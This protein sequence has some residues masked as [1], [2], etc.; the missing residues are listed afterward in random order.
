MNVLLGSS[1]PRRRELLEQ[2]GVEFTIA[3]PDIDETPL[4]GEGPVEYVRR[5]AVEKSQAQV[6]R[7]RF[8]QQ[9]RVGASVTIG[10]APHGAPLRSV[11]GELDV[12]AGR[13]QV[14]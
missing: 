9:V 10:D 2:L 8:G 4:P 3:G 14:G 12:I 13:V 6:P 11:V 1:S 7:L 5:L